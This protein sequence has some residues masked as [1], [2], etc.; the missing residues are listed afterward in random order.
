MAS[1]NNCIPTPSSASSRARPSLEALEGRLV[2]TIVLPTPGTPGPVVLT[3]TQSPQFFRVRL[4]AGSP[5]NLQVSDDGGNSY[6]TAAL[7]DVTEVDVNPFSLGGNGLTVDDGNGLVGKVGGLPVNYNVNP[8]GAPDT[9]ALSGNPGAA[10]QQ[11]Y[12]PVGGKYQLTTALSGA[13]G[14]VSQAVTFPAL[15]APIQDTVPGDLTVAGLPGAYAVIP[16]IPPVGGPGGTVPLRVQFVDRTG[17]D[18]AVD[19]A[20]DG[21]FLDGTGEGM[22]AIDFGNSGH[23]STVTV[24]NAG[25]VLLNDAANPSGVTRLTVD[26]GSAASTT[27]LDEAAPPGL[28][29]SLLNVDQTIT[30]PNGIFIAQLY[31]NRLDRAPSAG[32]VAHWEGVLGSGGRGA[33]VAGI[34]NSREGQTDVVDAWYRHYLGRG[35]SGG[36]EQSWVGLIAAGYR[37]EEVLASFLSSAEFGQNAGTSAGLI[38]LFYSTILDR[39]PTASESSVWQ[40]VLATQGKAAVARGL[41]LSTEFRTNEVF[42]FYDALLHRQPS[43]QEAVSWVFTGNYLADIRAAFEAGPEF[44]N[45]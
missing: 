31:A 19:S 14:V 10:T 13:L 28:P 20:A 38:G 42:R 5:T 43:L 4:E 29:V 32:E 22:P 11:T 7:A 45:A 44:Y 1:F 40:G 35:T 9:L 33:V 15:G 26:R 8:Q 6:Q 2:P 12:A 17:L 37:Q 41:L 16:T 25:V 3:G 34:E 23:P 24:R 21:N 30:D 27:L 36:E 18:L 39:A